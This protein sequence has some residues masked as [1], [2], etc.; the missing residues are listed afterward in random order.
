MN[1]TGKEASRLFNRTSLASIAKGDISFVKKLSKYYLNQKKTK[2]IS[3]VFDSILEKIGDEYRSEYY[4]KNIIAKKLLIGRHSLKTAT[5]QTEFRVGKSKADCVI[6]NGKSTCYEIKSDYDTL[7]RLP[8]QLSDYVKVFDEVF[9]VCTLKHL[10][11]VLDIA[12]I[13]VGVL[14]LTGKNTLSVKR[15]PLLREC[16]IDTEM[17]CHSLRKPEYIEMAEK[18][19]KKE[20]PVLPNSLIFTHC[21][22]IIK[23]HD[24]VVV[25]SLFVDI[26]KRSRVNNKEL[27][28]GLPISLLNAAI[29]Y[30]LSKQEEK[31]LISVFE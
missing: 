28:N 25:S 27:I 16:S 11:K 24:N 22:N 9:V 19:S 31:N 10:S 12:P 23:E 7:S 26:I 8:E 4:F 14:I 15:T 17:L 21:V 20:I 30:K 5:M 13:A 2:N 6:F 29:S 3:Y 18:L 1:I